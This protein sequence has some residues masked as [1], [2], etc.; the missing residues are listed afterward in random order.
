MSDLLSAGFARLWKSPVF[1]VLEG[2]AAL[3]AAVV[4]G[5][6][7][8]NA[9][10]FGPA[11]AAERANANFFLE[12]MYLGA[13]LAIFAGFYIGVEYS[14]GTL[15][16]KL[17][18]GHRRRDVY[19][20]DLL[21]CIAAGLLLLFT[22]AAVACTMSLTFLPAALALTRPAWSLFCAACIL[23]AYAALFTLAAMLDTDRS[24]MLVVS[25]VASL[26][27]L[28]AGMMVG[29]HLRDLELALK[30]VEARPD[31][32]ADPAGRCRMLLDMR[33]LFR[34]LEGLLPPAQIMYLTGQQGGAV[35]LPFCSLGLA[36]G[37]TSI[38]LALFQCKDLQ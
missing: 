12:M 16:N 18:T 20:A 17:I 24:R 8:M 23:M 2:A 37:S 21:V 11:W 29:S 4:Y 33:T 9:H 3:F 34:I 38:G 31:A 15:R 30:T 14:D 13:A 1:W 26:V 36:A 19:L 27:L 10:N 7:L 25:L 28:A 32:F 35:Y 6:A 5:L 22:H